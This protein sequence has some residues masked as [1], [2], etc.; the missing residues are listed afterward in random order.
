[1]IFIVIITFIVLR[2]L[3]GTKMAAQQESVKRRRRRPAENHFQPATL[4]SMWEE[5]A[6]KRTPGFKWDGSSYAS[7]RGQAMDEESLLQHSAALE[8]LLQVAP[9]GFPAHKPM[10]P[11]I[12]GAGHEAQIMTEQ[13]TESP[14]DQAPVMQ[15][16]ARVGERQIMQCL[17]LQRKG[18]TEGDPK[19]GHRD[20]RASRDQKHVISLV[21]SKS[22]NKGTLNTKAEAKG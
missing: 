17:L 7:A 15:Q 2:S 12:P 9:T 22:E 1:M 18:G 8:I 16:L 19:G 10:T 13:V 5:L 21:S 3:F 4:V 11:N 6:N 14:E 20:R